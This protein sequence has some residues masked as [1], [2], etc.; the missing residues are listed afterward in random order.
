MR[1]VPIWTLALLA[2][3]S[4][5]WAQSTVRVMTWNVET[6]GAR[7]SAQHVA[8]SQ[9]IGRFRPDVVGFNEISD[10][11]D[12]INLNNLAAD[13]GYSFVLAPGSNPFGGLRNA[14]MSRLPVTG[15]RVHLPSTLSGDPLANDM[16][17]LI[18]EVTVDP[19]GETRPLRVLINH[20]KSGDGDADE[21]RRAIESIRMAQALGAVS[22][23]SDA[24]VVMGDFNEEIQSVPRSPAVFSATP[25]GMPSGFRLGTDLAGQ[26]PTPGIANNPFAPVLGG[27]PSMIALDARQRDGTFTTRPASGRRIDYIVTSRA[28]AGWLPASEVFDSNDEAL[29]GGLVKFGSPLS[30][31]TS[32]IAADHLPIITDITVPPL[33]NAPIVLGFAD[34]AKVPGAGIVGPVDLA[35]LDP[36]TGLWGQALR[37]LDLYLP[38]GIDAA[39][40]LPS[41]DL[42]V[43]FATPALVPGLVGGPPG[44]VVDDSDIV[45]IRGSGVWIEHPP[46]SEAAPTIHFYF[47]G[48]DVGLD[49]DPEDV[50]ALAVL[51]DGRLLLSTIG[52]SGVPGL[53]W[54]DV[55]VVAF[56]PVSLGAKTAG[57]FSLYFDGSLVGLTPNSSE[58]VDALSVTPEGHLLISTLGSYSVTNLSGTSQDVVRFIPTGLGA[59]TAGGFLVHEAPR[60]YG[61]DPSENTANIVSR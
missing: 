28:L 54:D 21:F 58:D 37:G 22:T 43:S 35:R 47:D 11:A 10:A 27:T 49:T 39:H 7:G 13:T 12:V 45:L 20:W 18:V 55:D 16:T 57:A 52:A 42:L 8:V 2:L 36:R 4:P 50:D 53:A 60:S 48:S 51:P 24:Y 40:L 23:T 3:G 30:A 34:A 14:F 41:G 9:V 5:A 1:R 61:V 26:M 29:P 15:S 56:S 31:G 33:F 59:Q 38:A 6:L 19:P 44:D 25:S 46:S 32:A 17:R